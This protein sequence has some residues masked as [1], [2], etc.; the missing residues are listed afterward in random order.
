MAD[1]LL[2]GRRIVI[3]AQRRAEDLA[4]ALERHGAVV[5]HAATLSVV[6]HVDDAELL[7]RTRDLVEH[8]P[9]IVI[10]TTGVGLTGWLA[11]AREAGLEDALPA[12]LDRARLMVRGPKALGAARAAG[13]RVDFVAATE[14]DAEIRDVLLRENVT[15]RRVAIQHHGAGAD[16]L[17]EALTRAGADVVPVVVYRWG[18]APDP[19]AVEKAVRHVAAGEVDAVLFTA[20]PG[21]GAFL[22]AAAG[23]GLLDACVTA[24]RSGRVLAAAVGN[25]TSAPLEAA[26]VPVL[27]PDR[28]RL[29][30]LVRAVVTALEPTATR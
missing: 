18:P 7:S 1:T 12:A 8:A 23:M 4:G 11:A 20:A 24:F 21:A 27:V 26:G 15:G 29:G 9:D 10:V 16:G 22:D 19:A 14:T 30:A 28:F 25:V 13:L 17:D 3:T 2:A 6:P 5:E